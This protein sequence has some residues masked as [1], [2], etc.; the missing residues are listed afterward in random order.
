MLEWAL[1][2]LVTGTIAHIART[3]YLITDHTSDIATLEYLFL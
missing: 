1:Q 3:D 2:F